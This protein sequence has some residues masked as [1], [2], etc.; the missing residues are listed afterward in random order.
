M[1][2]IVSWRAGSEY[3]DKHDGAPLLLVSAKGIVLA[4]P[5][6][7]WVGQRLNA[8]AFETLVRVFA[9]NTVAMLPVRDGS[10]G[11]DQGLLSVSD[12]RRWHSFVV[13]PIRNPQGEVVAA[14][15][16]MEFVPYGYG[17]ILRPM[18]NQHHVIL[19][20]LFNASNGDIVQVVERPNAPGFTQCTTSDFAS[21]RSRTFDLESNSTT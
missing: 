16:A 15:A 21:R 11:L 13:A 10:L 1:R 8:D 17:E 20:A 19:I 2:C 18:S 7:H 9:G 12:A 6:P 5:S 14:A 3:A 4:D